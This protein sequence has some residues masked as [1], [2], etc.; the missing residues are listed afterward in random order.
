MLDVDCSGTG[1]SAVGHIVVRIV[2]LTGCS[3]RAGAAVSLEPKSSYPEIA[4]VLLTLLFVPRPQSSLSDVKLV[5]KPDAPDFCELTRPQQCQVRVLRCS[6]LR[7][8]AA[9]VVKAAASL[10]CRSRHRSV[11]QGHQVPPC[12]NLQLGLRCRCCGW[13]C[14]G[15]TSPCP[16]SSRTHGH[17][18]RGRQARQHQGEAQLQGLGLGRARTWRRNRARAVGWVA[19]R[20]HRLPRRRAPSA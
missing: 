15:R 11:G 19:A 20:C 16:T 14:S 6:A 8:S 10:G 7:S 2:L 12:M 13:R 18:P 9:A 4:G 5:I 1:D 3:C 17:R